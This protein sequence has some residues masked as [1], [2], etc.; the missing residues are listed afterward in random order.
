MDEKAPKRVVTVR[1]AHSREEAER[2]DRE[3][4]AQFTPDQKVAML[5]PLTIEGYAFAGLRIQPRLQRS[6]WR[7]E[8]S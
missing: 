5:W 4:W 7:V 6:S 3:W 8:R 2:F 1:V